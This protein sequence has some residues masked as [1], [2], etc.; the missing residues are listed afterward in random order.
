M[1]KIALAVLSLSMAPYTFA[2]TD[3]E[4]I[5]QQA[6]QNNGTYQAAVATYKAASY[7]IP[8]AMSAL[9]PSAVLTAS[10][11]ANRQSPGTP[12]SY[13]SNGFTLTLTQPLLAIGSWYGYSEA[14]ATYKQAAATYAAAQQNLIMTVAT[15]YFNVLEAE[16]QLKYAQAN[17]ASLAEQLRQ[18]DAQYKVGLKAMTDV[19]ATRASYESAVAST[20]SAQNSLNNAIQSLIAVTGRNEGVLSPLK[21]NFPLISPKPQDAQAWVNYGLKNNVNLQYQQFQADINRLQ[22]K[23]DFTNDFLPTVNLTGVYSNFNNPTSTSP[24]NSTNASVIGDGRVTTETGAINLNYNIFNGFGNAA[25]VK[26]DKF[27][28]EA[29]EANLIQTQRTTTQ[30]VSQAY[31]NVLS[32]ISQVE[33]LQQAVISGE[34]SLKAIRAGYMVGIRTIVDVLTQQSDLFNSQQQY[35]QAIYSYVTDSLNLKEQAGNLSPS[36]IAAVNT[37]LENQTSSPVVAKATT[38]NTTKVNTQTKAEST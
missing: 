28:Y 32:D 3:L 19:Q 38:T 13:N 11:A 26:Q 18:V 12:A 23:T 29:A 25:T 16:D 34:I 22:I 17:Q 20:V 24:D 15:S 10:T 36:D 27:N 30:N 1:K 5:Y 2:N 37:W 4:T 33:A 7:D 14:E 8:I 9:L 31:L 21:Q 6:A 35:A